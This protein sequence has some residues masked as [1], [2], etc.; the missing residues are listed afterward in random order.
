MQAMKDRLAEEEER[1]RDR[2]GQVIAQQYDLKV[3]TE[4]RVIQ[5][6]QVM[7]QRQVQVSET[8]VE[9]TERIRT[10]EAQRTAAGAQRISEQRSQVE[11]VIEQESDRQRKG[12]ALNEERLR[13]I[14]DQKRSTLAREAG[15]AQASEASRA[16]SKA[17]LDAT[18]KDQPR[19]FANYNRNKLAQEYPEGVTEESSTE[20]NKVIIR[21][22]VVKGNRADEYS[23]VI[24]KWGIYYFKNGQS[25]TEAI[26]TRETEG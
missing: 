18:P 26:W 16:R 6:E 14:D 5:K 11:Q 25:I 15:Y 24:A 3:A 12:A 21:R 17:R 22:I 19:D 10:A 23:K 9:Q 2:S 20:G 13:A 1:R 7:A 8:V 4:E